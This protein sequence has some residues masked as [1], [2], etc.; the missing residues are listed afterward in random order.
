MRIKAIEN[1]KDFL[2]LRLDWNRLAGISP[3]NFNWIYKWWWYYK[4]NNELKILIAEKDSKIVGIAP[5]YIYNEKILNF[6]NYKKLMILGGL[7]T[8]NLDFL[9]EKDVNKEVVFK[10]F[11]DYI[12]CNFKFDIFEFSKIYSTSEHFELCNKYSRV[13]KFN[14][15]EIMYYRKFDMTKFKSYEEYYNSLDGNLK[16]NL[17]FATNKIKNENVV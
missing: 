5:L 8:D 13:Y 4:K 1:E 2:A 6:L 12:L 14:F 10:A 3:N 11:W 9:I 7:I 17:N 16:K 15:Q